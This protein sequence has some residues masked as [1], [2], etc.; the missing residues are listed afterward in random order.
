VN[1]EDPQYG[2]KAK[3]YKQRGSGWQEYG[4][5][6][7]SVGGKDILKT[8][9]G[10]LLVIGSGPGDGDNVNKCKPN[11]APVPDAGDDIIV[12]KGE[13]VILDGS[14]TSD[15]E[16]DK[17][18]YHWEQPGAIMTAL[19]DEA[20]ATPSFVAKN[21]GNYIFQLSATDEY[22]A[23]STT[24]DQVIV[25]VVDGETFYLT[26]EGT[27]DHHSWNLGK[28]YSLGDAYF[29]SVKQDFDFPFKV[30]SDSYFVQ[31]APVEVGMYNIFS[32]KPS[33]SFV[34]YTVDSF[35]KVAIFMRTGSGFGLNGDTVTVKIRRGSLDGEVV[36]EASKFVEKSLVPHWEEFVF[37]APVEAQDN[38]PANPPADDGS[39]QGSGP[40]GGGSNG[41]SSGDDDNGPTIQCTSSSSCSGGL[42]CKNLKCVSCAKDSECKSGYKCT[43]G[44][45][46]KITT[47]ASSASGAST[48][49]KSSE[50]SVS[51]GSAE[52]AESPKA[53]TESSECSA[54]EACKDGVCAALE[55]EADQIVFNHKCT[56]SG[57]INLASFDFAKFRNWLISALVLMLLLVMLI[58][59]VVFGV[60]YKNRQEG[61]V[62]ESTSGNE[63]SKAEAKTA[64]TKAAKA[65]SR[66]K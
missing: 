20:T 62:A 25:T 10:S 4:L 27:V 21:P 61:E 44:K 29:S 17:I 19:K 7:K 23:E 53:C 48:D 49:D 12:F 2:Q 35:D 22:G 9:A 34:F 63:V 38:P 58:V 13:M 18:T 15:P 56:D 47:K 55:C 6:L 51:D 50:A 14:K 11:L 45:C 30:Y 54:S 33:Q 60:K 1:I 41:G 43:S 5:G 37:E 36:A 16:G 24:S 8:T 39:D 57:T 64:S 31:N 65:K 28:D 26:V 46:V 32:S 52:P 3:V 42:V 66:R 59:G 40:S